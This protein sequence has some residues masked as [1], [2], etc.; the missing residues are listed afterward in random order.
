MGGWFKVFDIGIVTHARDFFVTAYQ[1]FWIPTPLLWILG[2]SIPIIELVA[3][4]ML[5]LGL[6]IREASL[7]VGA[8]LVMVTYGHLLGD[9]MFPFGNHI[10]PRLVLLL[11]IMLT[12]AHLDAWNVDR[13]LSKS[14]TSDAPNGV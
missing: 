9:P 5:I 1:D 4:I 10:F 13:Y 3:G 7:M 12:P 14:K 11:V 2:V 6:R 8:V